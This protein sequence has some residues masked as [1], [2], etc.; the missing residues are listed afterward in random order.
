[1]VVE[2]GR[3]PVVVELGGMAPVVVEFG[4]NVGVTPV[5]LATGGTVELEE[6]V[7]ATAAKQDTPRRQTHKRN[8]PIN[9]IVNERG[10]IQ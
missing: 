3:T 7:V 8:N 1:V 10:M 6:L 2:L 9:L 4:S 5:V